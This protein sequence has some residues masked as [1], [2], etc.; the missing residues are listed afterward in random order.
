VLETAGLLTRMD[1]SVTTRIY[2]GMGH[3]VSDDEITVAQAVMDEA[4]RVTV[5]PGAGAI[6]RLSIEM[7]VRGWHRVAAITTTGRAAGLA[8]VKGHLGD[9]LID[10]ID[11]GAL[12]VPADRVGRALQRV[13][14]ARPD[15]LLAYGGG[16]AIG[17]AK[18]VALR[19]EY[20]LPIA[21]VP[22]TYSGS[23]MT[24]IWGITDGDQKQTG[25]DDRV[26]PRIVVYDPALTLT[27]SA[28]ASAA[29]GMNAIAHA[30][31]AL[32]AKS[33]SP[34][35][36][37]A[38]EQAIRLLARALPAIVAA[39]ADAGARAAALRGAHLAGVALQHA[40]MGLHHKLCH[41]LGGTF[42]LPHADT[43]AALLPHVVRFN[44]PAAPEAMARVAGALGAADAATGLHNLNNSLG[45]PASLGALGFRAS[46]IDRAADLSTASTY[47]NPRPVTADDVRTILQ[48]AL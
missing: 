42:G 9:R 16:S 26:A 14:S 8:A 39:T 17:L 18:A 36:A 40:S 32:Y 25:R 29:S 46:D 22:T 6:E 1:A 24:S 37:A 20:P 13:T 10:V 35:A 45:L 30:V 21:A 27:L 19:A 34:I 48:S 47:P 31:E 2:P 15:A 11:E 7:D 5:L 38:A 28:H 43:H 44:A 3:L 4:A 23:E 41:V 12:H 33:R